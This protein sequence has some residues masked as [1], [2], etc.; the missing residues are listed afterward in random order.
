M[1]IWFNASAE[2]SFKSKMR[3]SRFEHYVVNSFKARFNVGVE[4]RELFDRS[5]YSSFNAFS[6]NAKSFIKNSAPKL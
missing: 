3:D 4:V 1:R 6:G 5:R 2:S